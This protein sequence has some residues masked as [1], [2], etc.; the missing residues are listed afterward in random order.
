V[1]DVT[2]LLDTHTV[3]WWW[4]E[5]Q[6]L[7]PRALALITD[8]EN[9]CLVSAASAWETA[10]KVRIGKFPGGERTVEEWEE[11]LATDNF[12]EL[13]VSTRHAIKAGSLPGPHR[14]PFDRMIAA[15]SILEGL[16]VVSSDAALS[17]LGAERV[18]E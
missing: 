16:P 17:A 4:S 6:R 1:A 9:R 11:R 8:P 5:P 14:D 13:P 18:W 3:L 15:Q 10:T 2:L 7:S 12:T